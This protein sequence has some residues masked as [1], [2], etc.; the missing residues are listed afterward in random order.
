MDSYT[1]KNPEKFGGKGQAPHARFG[2][3]W[4][5]AEVG[6]KF[7]FHQKMSNS[8]DA[9]RLLSRIQ[10]DYA[11]EVREQFYETVSRK[12]FQEGRKLADHAM[13]QE[14]VQEIGLN[15]VGLRE[16]LAGDELTAEI[17]R[18]YAEIFYG[19]GY[20]SV[21]V[22]MVHCEGVDQVIQGSQDLDAYL[23]VFRKCIDDPHPELASSEK[24]PAWEA[25]SRMALRQ[26]TQHGQDF[27]WEAQDIFHGETCRLLRN[28]CARSSRGVA[29]GG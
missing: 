9:L 27:R 16:W 7:S 19:W 1:K 17:E 3:S 8:M 20:T 15:I 28:P 11:P 29:R 14:A 10:R 6:L 18:K 24:V 12:Y 26:G 5:A 13:L 4:Q 2:I 23:N 22:T 21:P 25:M